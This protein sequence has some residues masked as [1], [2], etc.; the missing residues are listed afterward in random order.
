MKLK[1]PAHGVI[2]T[3]LKQSSWWPPLRG[4]AGQWLSQSNWHSSYPPT[5][6]SP[7]LSVRWSPGR[8]GSSAPL[9]RWSRSSA[10]EQS[11]LLSAPPA[12]RQRHSHRPWGRCWPGSIRLPGKTHF[13]GEHEKIEWLGYLEWQAGEICTNLSEVVNGES[14]VAA[15]VKVLDVALLRGLVHRDHL[16]AVP[17]AL[18]GSDADS[19][20]GEGAGQGRALA[21]GVE[22][23]HAGVKSLQG[24]EGRVVGLLEEDMPC[25]QIIENSATEGGHQNNGSCIRHFI[26]KILATQ[27]NFFSDICYKIIFFLYVMCGVSH[28]VCTVTFRRL[29]G[30]GVL[31][32]ATFHS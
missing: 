12:R 21:G 18:I 31:A 24:V 19:V 8:G 29:D 5:P 25:A 14:V 20:D 22:L 7:L 1:S 17:A 13:R 23:R 32:R 26:F 15:I 2:K 16:A 10:P 28:W 27:G 30:G 6:C 3:H 4:Q 11:G 9:I